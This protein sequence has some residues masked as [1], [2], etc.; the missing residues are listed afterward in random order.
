M[1]IHAVN[2]LEEIFNFTYDRMG[3]AIMEFIF[4]VNRVLM[5]FM[6]AYMSYVIIINKCSK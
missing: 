1:I 6:L 5:Y 4:A 2:V 3:S